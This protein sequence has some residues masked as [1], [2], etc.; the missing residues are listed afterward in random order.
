MPITSTP[1]KVPYAQSVKTIPCMKRLP[2]PGV[3]RA[4]GNGATPGSPAGG[5]FTPKSRG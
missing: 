5:R 3:G 1:A 2:G 4:T